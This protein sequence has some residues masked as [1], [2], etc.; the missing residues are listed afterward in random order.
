LLVYM[1]LK[2]IKSINISGQINI[3]ISYE[4]VG[5]R[6]SANRAGIITIS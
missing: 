3:K 5:N 4:L 2:H 6:D 1:I